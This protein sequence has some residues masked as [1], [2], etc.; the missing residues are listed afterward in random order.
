MSL[1]PSFLHMGV[2]RWIASAPS[3]SV[4]AARVVWFHSRPWR[5]TQRWTGDLNKAKNTLSGPIY[6]DFWETDTL[7]ILHWSLTC[8]DMRRNP[9]LAI[10][11]AIGEACLI[12]QPIRQKA[13]DE[14]EK[15]GSL[16]WFEPLKQGTYQCANKFSLGIKPIFV[17]FSVIWN[18]N[19]LS[20]ST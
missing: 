1:P 3:F 10:L 13:D 2:C 6:Q 17:G 14:T 18:Q 8:E 19:T 20:S 5:L 15:P 12:R 16:M 9:V 11:P 7:P 4:S